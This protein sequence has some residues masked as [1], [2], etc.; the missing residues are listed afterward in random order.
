MSKS[1][2]TT[3]RIEIET[4]NAAFADHAPSEVARILRALAD[5]LDHCHGLPGYVPL[6]DLNGNKVG[7]AQEELTPRESAAMDDEPDGDCWEHRQPL[8]RCPARCRR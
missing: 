2:V 7:F 5:K 4:D 8:D 3:F 6:H 1:T